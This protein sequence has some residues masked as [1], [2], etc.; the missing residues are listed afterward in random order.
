[1]SLQRES[2]VMIADGQ[3][4]RNTVVA[5]LRA[6]IRFPARH[7]PRSSARPSVPLGRNSQID[8]LVVN[9]HNDILVVIVEGPIP[10]P[11]LPHPQHSLNRSPRRSRNVHVGLAIVAALSAL[12]VLLM[13]IAAGLG[14]GAGRDSAPTDLNCRD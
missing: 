14:H 11:N 10:L 1:M 6:T 2:S 8:I 4:P 5:G 9:W 12:V 7:R 3:P 13:I